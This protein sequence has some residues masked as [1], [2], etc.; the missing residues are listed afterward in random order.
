MSTFS[1]LHIFLISLT[2]SSWSIIEKLLLSP[3]ASACF[4]RS[5]ALIEWKVPSHGNPVASFLSNLETLNCISFAALFVKVTAKI[6]FGNALFFFIICAILEVRTL[7]LP[8]PAPATIKRGPS[9]HSTAS[10]WFSFK[11]LKY[12]EFNI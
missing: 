1:A 3:T 12:S 2:W 8:D 4:L 11:L 5:F 6:W 10:L 9:K 7:V